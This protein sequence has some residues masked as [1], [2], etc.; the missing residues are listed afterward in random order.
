MERTI[1]SQELDQNPSEAARLA[2][3]GPVI[4]T[5]L[6]E[7][8]FVLLRYDALCRLA[9]EKGLSITDVLNDNHP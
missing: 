3:D 9:Q 2:E 5:D 7:P 1:S 4:V 6:G 8:A